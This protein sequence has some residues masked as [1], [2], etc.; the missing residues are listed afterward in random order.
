MSENLSERA[1]MIERALDETLRPHAVERQALRD[2]DAELTLLRRM[3]QQFLE[4]YVDPIMGPN[5]DHEIVD[6]LR[7]FI[8]EQEGASLAEDR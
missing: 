3:A 7:E 4:H 5:M 1:A 8:K 6:Y 2:M